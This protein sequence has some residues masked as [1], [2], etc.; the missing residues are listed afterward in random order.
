MISWALFLHLLGRLIPSFFRTMDSTILD[1]LD[2][3]I[4]HLTHIQNYSRTTTQSIRSVVKFFVTST[5]INDIRRVSRDRVEDWLL[6]GRIKRG[7]KSV[8]YIDYHKRLNTFF[9]WLEK[10]GKIERNFIPDIDTPRLEKPLP[11]RL[12]MEQA[13]LLLQ[14]CRRIRYTYRFEKARNYAFIAL[15][16]FTWLRKSEVANLKMADVTLDT[17]TITVFHGKWWKDRVMPISSRLAVILR[18]YLAERTRLAKTCEGFFASAQLDRSMSAQCIDR[19]IE[20]LRERTWIHFSAHY[21]RHS[22]A[23]MM[24]EGGCDIYTLSKMLWHTKVTTTTVY[25]SCSAKQLM[26]SIERHPMN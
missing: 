3:C 9:R 16:L 6:E 7:W 22:F 5:G 24:I 13:E 4:L 2:Q 12:T 18:E 26:S 8:T 11:K 17:M 14:T 23:T 25:L 1:L 20:R 10:K 19:F 15:M 21:L